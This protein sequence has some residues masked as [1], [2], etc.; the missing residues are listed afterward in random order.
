MKLLKGRTRS[1]ALPLLASALLWVVGS[2]AASAQVSTQKA[3]LLLVRGRIF[4]ADDLTSIHRA[5]AIR[6]GRIVEVGGDDLEDRYEAGRI[7]DLQ[8]RLV[9]P[10]FNDTHIHVRGN[11][12]RYIDF[13]GTASIEEFK[14]KVRAKAAELGP[15]EWITGWGW[16]EDEMAE[17]RR[18]LRQDVDE[19]APDN[20]VVIRRAGGHSSVV[21]SLA[22]ELAGIDRDTPDPEAGVIERDDTGELNGIIR[23]RADL[24]SRLV[25]RATP[26]ELRESLVEN[27]RG[28]L[29]LGITSIIQAGETTE[30][31]RFW[32]EI[33]SEHGAA[34]PRV[35]VQ[36]RAG[37]DA[38]ETLERLEDLGMHPGEGDERFRVGP[39]KLLVDGGY[40]G[41]AAWT[42][43][44][45]WNQPDYFG[46][47][48]FSEQELYEISKAAHERGWQLG[49]HAIGDA[50]IKV[51][52][53]AWRR[54]LDESPRVAH[55]HF[56]NHFTVLPPVETLRTMADYNIL[57]AQQPNFAYTLE[58]RYAEHLEGER[59]QSNNPVRTPMSHGIFVALGSDILP[60][61][62]M[63]GLYAAVTRKGMSGQ[64]YGPG[65][66]LTVPEAIVGYT[67]NGAYLT[68]E[69]D[70]KGTL[71][72]GKLADLIVLSDDLLTI[73][74]ERILE[75]QVDMTILGGRV[76]Y[77][78]GTP[79]TTP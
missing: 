35:A 31:V 56:L 71:E 25:P 74:P 34:L 15:G 75:V 29:A 5:V 50:A 2:G 9:T 24:V 66:R 58:G 63:V 65:E 39:L 32:Q 38:A 14:E 26:E 73:D 78:R 61:G 37:S 13:S 22:L 16:S 68:F 27:L 52:V 18:P 45:Y 48:R 54:L 23:E 47:G 41:P 36:P 55:R 12:R 69:E 57:I 19:A 70:R 1:P 67:R 59:L 28:L 40:T 44:P 53:D 43:E 77:E 8:G 20:P 62:P 72:P 79:N 6:E 17:E 3:D 21:N 64:V 11:P 49:F 30:G 42:L 46:H 76:V 33:Y 51:T 10:G 4:T 7:V 60:I